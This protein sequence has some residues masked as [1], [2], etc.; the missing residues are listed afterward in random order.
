MSCEVFQKDADGKR[1]VIVDYSGWLGSAAIAAVEWTV[2]AQLTATGDS[3]TN[4]TATNHFAGGV[5]GQEYEL[6]CCITTN[7]AETRIKCVTFHIDV[8]DN[9]D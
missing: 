2:P 7:D 9:C 3:F 5:D 6:K 4:T 1:R 8:R